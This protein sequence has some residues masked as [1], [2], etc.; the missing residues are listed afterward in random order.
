MEEREKY[1]FETEEEYQKRNKNLRN[2]TELLESYKRDPTETGIKLRIQLGIASNFFFFLFSFNFFFL[3][4]LKSSY[5]LST[6][7]NKVM[8][9]LVYMR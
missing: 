9:L 5:I 3:F 2:I 1:S 6:I 4:I 7:F 8:K